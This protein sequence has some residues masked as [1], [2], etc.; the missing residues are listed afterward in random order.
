MAKMRH[1][2]LTDRATVCGQLKMSLT[3]PHFLHPFQ[4]SKEKTF[5]V[6][7][8]EISGGKFLS[9]NF[10]KFPTPISNF[11]K[12]IAYT[13]DG[14]G[15]HEQVVFSSATQLQARADLLVKQLQDEEALQIGEDSFEWLEGW[16]NA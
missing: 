11:R 6:K 8:P 10:R 7:F 9:G 14:D 13:I 2:G 1:E 15:D 12:F 3:V 5:W 16:K 4:G